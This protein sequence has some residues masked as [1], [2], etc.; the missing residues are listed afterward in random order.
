VKARKKIDLHCQRQKSSPARD[1]ILYGD[2]AYEDIRRLRCVNSDK[3]VCVYSG[4]VWCHFGW[5]SAWGRVL[6]L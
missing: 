4:Y 5:Y 3:R 6:R 2:K 1:S